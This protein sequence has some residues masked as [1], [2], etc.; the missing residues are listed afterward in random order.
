MKICCQSCNYKIEL[1]MNKVSFSFSSKGSQLL[2]H[3]NL[4]FQSHWAIPVVVERKLSFNPYK[5]REDIKQKRKKE[6]KRECPNHCQR[7]KA[8]GKS[9][10]LVL[11]LVSILIETKSYQQPYSQQIYIYHFVSTVDHRAWVGHTAIK[12]NVVVHD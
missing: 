2:H 9:Q 11:F 3:D 5:M 7:Q 12:K 6:G 8:K 1:V 4:P 10:M